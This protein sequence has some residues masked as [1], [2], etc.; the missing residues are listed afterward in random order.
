[1][2]QK[3]SK[4]HPTETRRK[5]LE[6]KFPACPFCGEIPRYAAHKN[7]CEKNPDAQKNRDKVRDAAKKAY[8]DNGIAEKAKIGQEKNR[9]KIIENGKRAYQRWKE[10]GIVSRKGNTKPKSAETR[11]KM[12]EAHLKN[13]LKKPKSIKGALNKANVVSP[14]IE[15]MQDFSLFDDPFFKNMNKMDNEG[16]IEVEEWSINDF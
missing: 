10:Q 14:M 15:N 8:I 12:S 16:W 1:M 9:D 13:G 11:K 4:I 6:R 7:Y 2:A 3:I 5:L